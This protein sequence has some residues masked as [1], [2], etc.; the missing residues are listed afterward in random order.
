[1]ETITRLRE[2][3]AQ[4][5]ARLNQIDNILRRY[6]EWDREAKRLLAI[7]DAASIVSECVSTDAAAPGVVTPEVTAGADAASVPARK[8]VR[9]SM[10]EFEAAVLDVLRE[11]D[12]PMDRV[13]LYDAL[14]GRG[15]II[16]DGDRDKELNALSARVYRMARGGGIVSQRGEGYRLRRDDESAQDGVAADQSANGGDPDDLR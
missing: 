1:M 5:V 3:R 4:L 14:I 2:E 9:T 15:I 7:N 8:R 13:A 6:E 12:V 10:K 16:G 11:S